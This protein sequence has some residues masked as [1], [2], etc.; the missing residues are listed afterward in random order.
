MVTTTGYDPQSQTWSEH[1]RWGYD[2]E[3][4][5]LY[6][7][8][9]N[10][11]RYDIHCGIYLIIRKVKIGDEY[12][13]TMDEHDKWEM[14]NITET[15]ET[16][17]RSYITALNGT[18][19]YFDWDKNPVSWVE[20]F[21]VL[22]PGANYTRVIPFSWQPQQIFEDIMKGINNKA[23]VT[24][25]H[26]RARAI[27][28]AISQAQAGDTVLIA[29]KGHETYQILSDRTVHFDDREVA[30]EVLVA[31]GGQRS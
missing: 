23:E 18:K 31:A 16:I 4:S 10:G 21:H 8:T 5:T 12:Y 30:A 27:R 1:N 6:I 14:M 26:D 13:Y 2:R 25:E 17:Y 29:G 15:G 24:C 20:E 19:I 28:L 11:T 7:V 22:V 3:N 9:P